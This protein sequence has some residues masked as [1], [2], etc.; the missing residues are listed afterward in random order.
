MLSFDAKNCKLLEIFS[1]PYVKNPSIC[2]IFYIEWV[3]I[4][5]NRE[6]PYQSLIAFVFRRF[7]SSVKVS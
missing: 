6:I 2:R 3:V 1:N 5:S 4:K 7:I